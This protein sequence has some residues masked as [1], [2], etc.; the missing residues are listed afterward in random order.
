MDESIDLLGEASVFSTIDCNSG[1]WQIP[2]R[3]QDRDKT[4]FVCH[5]GLYRYKRMPFGLT[6]APATFQRT[7]DILLSPYKWRSCLV[8]L[9]DIIIFSKSVEKHFQHV[10]E[11]ITTLK[12][13]GISF[14]LKKCSFF[15]NI[16]KYLGHIIHP[17][18]LEVDATHTT[19][20]KRAKHPTTQTQLRA[21]LALCNVYRRFVPKYSHIAA[22]LTQRTTVQGPTG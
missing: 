3:K 9:E 5:A 13:A 17:G 1:Y 11:I 12:S 10:E 15:T 19:A 2:V 16:V 7:L 18:T 21:F 6:N 4:A 14:K 20:L 22:P 8:Y